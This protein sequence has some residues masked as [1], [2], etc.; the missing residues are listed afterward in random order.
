[1]TKK[2]SFKASDVNR[3]PGDQPFVWHQAE[4][5]RSPAWRRRS[6]NCIRL[7]DFLLV[8]QMAHAGLENGNLLAPF[9]QLEAW[10]IG[11]RLIADAVDEAE[12]LGLIG[13]RRGGR[14]GLVANHLS[15]YRLTF[16]ATRC[17]PEGTAKPYWSGPTNEWQRFKTADEVDAAIAAARAAREK[18]RRSLKNR[19]QV[20]EGEPVPVHEG[21]LVQCTK[22]NCKSA[23]SAENRQ[24]A[25]VHESEPLYIS[26]RDREPPAGAGRVAVPRRSEAARVPAPPLLANPPF[27]QAFG[28]AKILAARDE[29]KSGAAGH[30]QIDTEDFIEGGPVAIG[31]IL[32]R[33]LQ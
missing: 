33:I 5:L 16:Y 2:L 23:K 7:V 30:D 32:K 24:I 21:E 6:I 4:L 20:H 22:V 1:V 26:T 15:T 28:S 31:T 11:R 12:A 10:G 29:G 27:D 3:P 9:D 14:K 25:T 17:T 8:E 19:K 13:V 18:Q